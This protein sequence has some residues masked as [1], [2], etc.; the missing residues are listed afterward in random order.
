MTEIPKDSNTYHLAPDDIS[1]YA[2]NDYWEQRYIKSKEDEIFEWYGGY[3][4]FKP[5]FDEYIHN[6]D[7][8][9]FHYSFIIYVL[10]L[11]VLFVGCGNSMI[12]EDM[13]KS[14]EGSIDAIDISSTCIRNM[15]A[16]HKDSLRN[17]IEFKA[18]VTYRV[19]DATKMSYPRHSFKCVI[20]KGTLDALNCGSFKVVLKL[21][22][23]MDRICDD[24]H[25]FIITQMSD[26]ERIQEF[27]SDVIP[28]FDWKHYKYSIN[29]HRPS[30]LKEGE[31]PAVYVITKTKRRLIRVIDIARDIQEISMD[32]I[33]YE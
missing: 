20:D 24:G 21:M 16:I 13:A 3:D 8:I 33:E 19:M 26:D 4:T 31:S 22:K 32:I 6:D 23:E 5:I 9:S 30:E 29:I 25:I 11:Y 28:E 1:N 7:A 10:C 14:H 2:S 18:P 17:H 27:M 12:S 15:K